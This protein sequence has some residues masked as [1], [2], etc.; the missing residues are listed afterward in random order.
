MSFQSLVFILYLQYIS[1]WTS[2]ISSTQKLHVAGG[3]HSGEHRSRGVLAMSKPHFPYLEIGTAPSSQG[4]SE[5]SPME[6]EDV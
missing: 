3:C 6:C 2:H 1:I 5:D 4:F